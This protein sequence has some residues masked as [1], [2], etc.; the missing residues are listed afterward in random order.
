METDS[1]PAAETKPPKLR[2]YQWRLRSLFLLT[3][4]VAV[5]MSWLNGY[6]IPSVGSN[7]GKKNPARHRPV[8]ARSVSPD[9]PPS[10]KAA[11]KVVFSG[12]QRTTTTRDTSCPIVY[13]G[14]SGDGGR[15]VSSP[16]AP[17]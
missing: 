11:K 14:F 15:H 12:A 16:L 2:W 8:V 17:G 5:D 13:P 9:V 4:L 7:S 6:L 3:L 1:L 10:D